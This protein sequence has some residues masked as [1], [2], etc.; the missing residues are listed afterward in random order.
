MLGAAAQSKGFCIHVYIY[1]CVYAVTFFSAGKIVYIN[2]CEMYLPPLSLC[3]LVVVAL[4][5]PQQTNV[6]LA[7]VCCLCFVS[8]CFLLFCFF[9]FVWCLI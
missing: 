3:V 2:I 8:F 6:F 4:R 9:V 5:A 7:V 1:I